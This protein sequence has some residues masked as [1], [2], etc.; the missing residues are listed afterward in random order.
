MNGRWFNRLQM[1]R[2]VLSE[3]KYGEAG[4]LRVMHA[5]GWMYLGIL[6]TVRLAGRTK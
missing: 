4:I 6:N 3:P 5:L 2:Y 1:V